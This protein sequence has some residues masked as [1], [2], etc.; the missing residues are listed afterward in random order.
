MPEGRL[1]PQGSGFAYEYHL[2]DHLGNTRV[3]YIAG[4]NGST[5]ISQNTAYYPFGLQ[6]KNKKF[7]NF[8][9]FF[10]E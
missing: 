6:I 8:A 7:K 1:L 4:A 2:K 3:T 9:F 5:A 10:R